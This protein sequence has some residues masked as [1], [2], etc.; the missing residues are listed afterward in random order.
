MANVKCLFAIEQQWAGP[1]HCAWH[2]HACTEIIFYRHCTGWLS[3]G[4][5]RHRYGDGDVAV[6]QPG[7]EHADDTET[8]GTHLCVGIKG[9]GVETVPCGV[10]PT[11]PDLRQLAETIRGELNCGG[12]DR[13]T[14]LDVLAGWLALE[15]RRLF[16]APAP[17]ADPLPYHVQAAKRILDTQFT[18]PLSI[19]EVAETLFINPDYLRQLFRET[20]GESPL[21][22]L[23]RRRLEAARELLGMTTLT[24]AE[25]ARQAGFDNAYYF[26]RL[27][28]KHTG[29][30]PTA[31]RERHR[32]EM[33]TRSS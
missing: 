2:S 21:H 15:L 30:T 31:Y 13:E 28:K 16:L 27:F 1:N 5:H 19:R 7:L 32:R 14:R 26:C 17:V 33:A 10:W 9:C 12:D 18:A 4:G 3:Q 29:E 8:P 6:Y 24:V 20:L 25:A 23:I 22:Y 11:P